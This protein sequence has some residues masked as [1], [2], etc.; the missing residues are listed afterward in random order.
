MPTIPLS[1]YIILN[2]SLTTIQKNSYA[3]LWYFQNC[4]V[5]VYGPNL[6]YIERRRVQV[7]QNS[8]VRFIC[9][10][11]RREHISW[12]RRSLGWLDMEANR[13][14]HAACLYKK[15]IDSQTPQYLLER[16]NCRSNTHNSNIRS[17]NLLTIPRHNKQLFKRS[18]SYQ[19]VS[20][21]NKIDNNLMS[22]NTMKFKLA[23]SKTLM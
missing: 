1:S 6:T 18:T 2:T 22:L 9:G 5:A 21:Y 3:E 10:I 7:L 8:C 12:P 20:V 4:A 15:I 11:R 16:V 14:I 17:K 13:F 23:L 19:I